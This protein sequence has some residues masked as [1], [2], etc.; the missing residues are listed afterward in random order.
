LKAGCGQSIRLFDADANFNSIN[1]IASEAKQS[2][3]LETQQKEKAGLLRRKRSS[4]RRCE[5]FD[6]ELNQRY[7][8][9]R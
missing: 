1:V 5:S 8:P 4:Q 9:S 2:S 6:S 3:F 7:A